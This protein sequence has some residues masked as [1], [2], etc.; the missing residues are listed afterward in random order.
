MYLKNG[1]GLYRI[2]LLFICM[3]YMF[4]FRFSS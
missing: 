4:V 1:L 2:S 3:I